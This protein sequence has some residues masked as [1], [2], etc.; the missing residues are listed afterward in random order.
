MSARAKAS[1]DLGLVWGYVYMNSQ[2]WK[3]IS[4]V[5][6]VLSLELMRIQ[7]LSHFG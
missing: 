7:S 6:D 5:A 4:D 2:I 1:E 3:N